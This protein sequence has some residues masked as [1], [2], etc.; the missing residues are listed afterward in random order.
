MASPSVTKQSSDPLYTS[1]GYAVGTLWANYSNGTLWVCT[2]SSSNDM[3]WR[4]CGTRSSGVNN[5][6]G[7]WGM[8]GNLSGFTS[9]GTAAANTVTIDKYT[10]ASS[11]NAT[12]HGD[13]TITSNRTSGSS[14][15]THGYTAGGATNTT[16]IDKFT[17]ATTGNA[18]EHADLT[19][20]RGNTAGQTSRTHGFASGGYTGS[21]V[22]DTID[23]FSFS[24]ANIIADH[25]NLSVARKDCCG[26]SSETKGYTSGGYTSTHAANVDYFNFSSNTTA[27]AHGNLS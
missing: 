16:T 19:L 3:Y 17:F 12:D 6:S 7:V 5:G 25:G 23:K 24:N 11:G 18:T 1:N 10:F 2:Q 14:S 9:G 15:N 20:A 21:S 27:T 13:L 22:S 4:N 26:Q 8:Q